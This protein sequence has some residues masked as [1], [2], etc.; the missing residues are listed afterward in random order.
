MWVAEDCIPRRRHALHPC[1]EDVHLDKQRALELH[2]G[3][4]G[5]R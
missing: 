5:V 1:T 2:T 4:E 3:Y